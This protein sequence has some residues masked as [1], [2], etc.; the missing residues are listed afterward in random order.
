[1]SKQF[2]QFFSAEIETETE[3]ARSLRVTV[4]HLAYSHLARQFSA[5]IGLPSVLSS[6][7]L[8]C[9]PCSASVNDRLRRGRTSRQESVTGRWLIV[10]KWNLRTLW[11]I[12]DLRGGGALLRY[13]VQVRFIGTDN[14][15]IHSVYEYLLQQQKGKSPPVRQ[16]TCMCNM[17]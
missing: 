6:G 2:K 13:A 5:G 7:T 11:P 1:L 17:W 12:S 8:H 16:F 10:W 14:Y 4:C 15:T 9:Q 3:F